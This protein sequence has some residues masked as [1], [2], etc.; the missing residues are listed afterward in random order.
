M[1]APVGSILALLQSSETQSS[2]TELLLRAS[3]IAKGVLLLLL[4]FSVASWSIIFAKWVWFRRAERATRDFLSRFRKS[5]KLSDLYLNSESNGHS[6]LARVF[7]SGYE[8]ITNQMNEAGGEV[9]SIEAVSR[10]L[11]S[12]TIDEVVKMERSLS[13]LASTANACPFIGLFG[14]VVGIIIAFH[15]LTTATSS[16]IQ[17]VAPGIA[18]ALIATAA[19]IAAAVPAAVFYN[20]FVNRIKVVTAATDRFSLELI[21]FVERHYVRIETVTR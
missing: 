21:N 5:S 16:S 7:L 9:R 10:V 11:Q 12:A 4:I 1:T 2:L 20:H 19:G 15:G 13:W 17:A 14:T 6:P 3:P 18:E 8:E